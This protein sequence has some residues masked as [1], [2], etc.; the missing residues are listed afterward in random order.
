MQGN[1]TF[2]ILRQKIEQN[3]GIRF[4]GTHF[5][6]ETSIWAT[7][8]HNTFTRSKDSRWGMT[9]PEWGTEIREDAL[10]MVGNIG[11][12]YSHNS[13][14]AQVAQ[15][16]GTLFAGEGTCREHPPAPAPGLLLQPRWFLEASHELSPQHMQMP[17]TPHGPRQLLWQQVPGGLQ[18]TQLWW[19]LVYSSTG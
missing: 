14:Q 13:D 7:I 8:L 10:R 17:A 2:E 6:P 1:A 11:L 4:S 15:C 9:V 19:R 3:N 12:Y 16:K 5:F 18:E